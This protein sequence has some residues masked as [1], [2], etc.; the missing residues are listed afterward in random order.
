M[1]IIV[2]VND[3]AINICNNEL[4]TIKEINHDDIIVHNNDRDV[5][6]PINKFQQL[7]YVAYCI[8][9]CKSQGSTFNRSYTIHEFNR[10]DM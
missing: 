2:R 5:T 3:S 9:V 10:F 1:P 4:Y 7:F 6:I 8:T